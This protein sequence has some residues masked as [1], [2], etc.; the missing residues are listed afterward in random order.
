VS[1]LCGHLGAFP[2]DCKSA[3]VGRVTNS[4]AHVAFDSIV[5]N[6]HVTVHGVGASMT[7]RE[8]EIAYHESLE[9]IEAFRAALRL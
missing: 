2:W 3:F 4:P 6:R 5:N 9:V 1:E 7:F 8:L